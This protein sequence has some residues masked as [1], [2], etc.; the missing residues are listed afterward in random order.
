MNAAEDGDGSND[1]MRSPL[2]SLGT[3]FLEIT[4]PRL[5]KRRDYISSG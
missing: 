3:R 4:N 5:F 1:R 2:G